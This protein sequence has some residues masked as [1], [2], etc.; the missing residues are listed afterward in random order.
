[1]VHNQPSRPV[2]LYPLA[3]EHFLSIQGSALA[4]ER[5][6]G[7]RLAAFQVAGDRPRISLGQDRRR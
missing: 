4:D 7:V 2:C 3:C 5:G 1:M 6:S